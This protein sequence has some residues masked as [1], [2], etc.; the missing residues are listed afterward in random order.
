MFELFISVCQQ[1]QKLY[2]E[3]LMSLDFVLNRL[4]RLYDLNSAFSSKYNQWLQLHAFHIQDPDDKL[5]SLE[6]TIKSIEFEIYLIQTYCHVCSLNTPSHR[7]NDL[8]LNLKSVMELNK[9]AIKDSIKNDTRTLSVLLPNYYIYRDPY[10][11]NSTSTSLYDIHAIQRHVDEMT[12]KLKNIELNEKSGL[13]SDSSYDNINHVPNRLDHLPTAPNT[14]Y[15][16][17]LRFR[18][19]N[20]EQ[21]RTNLMSKTMLCQSCFDAIESKKLAMHN[22]FKI[23]YDTRSLQRNIIGEHIDTLLQDLIDIFQ[24]TSIDN[25]N[26][27]RSKM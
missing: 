13:P 25:N 7:D 16:D 2:D 6:N 12:D 22:M 15:L 11:I 20:A 10:K 1:K 24:K 8:D 14:V 19:T 18:I 9:I 27:K 4:N 23:T 17:F 3:N 5:F 26:K 21:Y